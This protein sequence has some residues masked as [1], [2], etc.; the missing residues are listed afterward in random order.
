MSRVTVDVNGLSLVR[1]RRRR[2]ERDAARRVSD[3]AA[4]RAAPYPNVAR[5]RDLARGSSQ[6]RADGGRRIALAG[7]VFQKS[8]GDEPGAGGGVTS[9]VTGAEATW[10]THSFD[11]AIDA[12]PGDRQGHLGLSPGLSPGVKE[13]GS[14]W[15]G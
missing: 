4:L 11:V 2:L 9:G 5:S 10:L 12:R 3:A 1:R 14:R 7:S 8:T 15:S 13:S 6:V